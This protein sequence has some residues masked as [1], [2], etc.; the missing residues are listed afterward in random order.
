MEDENY[1]YNKIKITI[2]PKDKE[3]LIEFLKSKNYRNFTE[4][5]DFHVYIRSTV[6]VRDGR[7]LMKMKKGNRFNLGVTEVGEDYKDEEVFYLELHVPPNTFQMGFTPNYLIKLF[8]E[9]IIKTLD[10]K[11]AQLKNDYKE[12][13]ERKARQLSKALAAA[14]TNCR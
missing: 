6:R 10:S 5:Y 14:R 9:S 8:D 12:L 1:N 3:N 7:N 13:E 11:Y 2:D 4:S